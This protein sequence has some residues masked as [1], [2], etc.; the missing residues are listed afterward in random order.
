MS[1]LFRPAYGL[2]RSEF[3]RAADSARSFT[4]SQFFGADDGGSRPNFEQR[5][6]RTS[7]EVNAML[8]NVPARGGPAGARGSAG[9]ARG[10]V[11]GL[12]SLPRRGRG[13]LGLFRGLGRGRGGTGMGTG[14]RGRGAR[15]QGR[16]AAGGGRGRGPARRK[17]EDAEGQ[18]DAEYAARR[19]AKGKVNKDPETAEE[20]ESRL[21]R[22]VG[23]ESRYAPSTTLASLTPFL[24]EVPA[25]SNPLGRLAAA[26]NSLRVLAGGHV[27]TNPV[28]H[29]DDMWR[30][31]KADGAMF[32]TDLRARRALEAKGEVGGADG[33]VR[34]TITRR[35][36]MGEHE[37][38]EAP[39]V[40]DAA[41]LARS[42][43]IRGGCYQGRK[44]GEFE[45]KLAEL[46]AK[47]KVR[48]AAPKQVKKEE[49]PAKGKG[50]KAKAKA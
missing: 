48:Q 5:S 32:F 21:E 38:V 11:V 29:R 40:K 8:K 12:Q 16:G 3:H 13:G 34:E 45:G 37:S 9:G 47:A 20:R 43:L 6:E 42:A 25:D 35:V 10:K 39:E 33:V 36:V 7:K 44:L 22:E 49:E 50:K 27:D 15:G 18:S 28:I 30:Q 19:E 41:G 24:P 4:T 14:M 2:S 17:R 26:M 46:V 1:R 31:Y 23:V